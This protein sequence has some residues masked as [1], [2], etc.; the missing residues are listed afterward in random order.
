MKNA[1]N[2]LKVRKLFP[3]F[4]L[5]LLIYPSLSAQMNRPHDQLRA[6]KAACYAFTGVNLVP[7]PGKHIPNGIL[8]IRNGFVD[9]AGANVE[10]PADAIVINLDGRWIFPGFI[11]AWSDYGQPDAEPERGNDPQYER[12]H[13][14]ARHWN[15]AVKPEFVGSDHFSVNKKDAEARRADGFTTLHSVPK[16]G[17][18]RGTSA[19]VNLDTEPETAVLSARTGSCLSFS[20]GVSRQEYPSSLMGTIALMRQTFIDAEWYGYANSLAPKE[21]CLAPDPNISFEALDRQMKGKM[22]FFLEAGDYQHVL[23]GHKVA[24]EAGLEFIFKT[25]GNEFER[26]GEMKNKRLIVPLDFPKAYEVNDIADARYVSLGQLRAWE[27]A[28]LNPAVLAENKVQFAL[29]SAGLK[30]GKFWK[31]LQRALEYG[32]SEED[33]L[34]A[35]TLTPAEFLGVEKQAGSLEKGKRADFFICSGNPFTHK[36][37]TIHEVW[38]GGQRFVHEPVPQLDITG[39]YALVLPGKQLK[40][41]LE[42]TKARAIDGTDTLKADLE[43]TANEVLLTIGKGK[44]TLRL[45]GS[46]DKTDWEGYGE[47]LQGDRFFWTAKL[48]RSLDP[49]D[50]SKSKIERID[51]DRIA[52]VTFPNTSYGYTSLPEQGEWLIQGATVWTNGPKG[53]IESADVLIRNGKIAKVGPNLPAGNATVIDGKGLHVTPGIIDEHSHIAIS[54]G[55]NEGSHAVT[56]EVRIGDVI[57]S[58]DIS[59]YRQLGGGVTASQLLH[60]SANPIGGQSGLIKLRWGWLPEEMKI[61]T[62]DGFIKFAL[63]ENVKQSNWGG[64]NTIRYPQTRLGVE[65]L[66]KDAFQAAL[67]YRAHQKRW[68]SGERAGLLPRRRDLQLETLLEILDR[69]RFVTCHSYQQGEIL[70]LMRLAESLG[71]RINTF[72]HVLEGYKI[73]NEIAA[74]GASGSTFSD[75]WAYK[76]EVIDAVPYNAAL[77]NEAGINVCINSD[78]AEMGRRL[79]QEAAKAVKYGG[80]SE[81]DALKMVTLNPAKA[82]HL[83]NRMGKIMA[84]MDADVVIWSDHPLSIYAV[85]QKTFIDGRLMFD[86][87]KDEEMR[88]AIRQERTRL[89]RKMIAD[90]S[91]E[92]IKAPQDGGQRHYHCDTVGE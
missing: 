61:E 66:M 81:E 69:K 27:Q 46:G 32:L 75:W 71:F 11:D 6:S 60:G 4:L 13:P 63:G 19:W 92:K 42:S 28:P 62:P 59:I 9:N 7:Q 58:E 47:N 77:M 76:Y 39:E 21:K 48:V 12:N 67:D 87:E 10:I 45:R 56:A 36:N 18:F 30:P 90:D 40:L 41:Q 74:H 79:N 86:L 23:R 16:D 5:F 73:A 85:A 25:R 17:V 3:V 43:V 26:V 51:T 80:V 65:Q 83:D 44:E 91:D 54:R 52:P 68:E 50:K 82:L 35:L 55:V 78:D 84:G 33:A 24:E 34:R 72:T 88:S 2:F 64:E 20:K 8:I 53:K 89:I 57:N 49:A 70:M 38:V 37:E 31:N 29:T 22:P 14:G 15:E 1:P